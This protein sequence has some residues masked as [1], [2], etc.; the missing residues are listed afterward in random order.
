MIGWILTTV[1]R[2][3]CYCVITDHVQSVPDAQEAM[4][5]GMGKKP[6]GGYV[7]LHGITYWFWIRNKEGNLR[8]F[9]AFD[10]N[11]RSGEGVDFLMTGQ[12]LVDVPRKEEK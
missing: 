5:A 8:R 6:I 10:V 1:R 4:R 3:N 2:F 7:V 11:I 12:G 9:E